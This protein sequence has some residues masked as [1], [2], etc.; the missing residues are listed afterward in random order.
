MFL[1]VDGQLVIYHST[2]G[3]TGSCP[4]TVV[5][6][7]PQVEPLCLSAFVTA[8]LRAYLVF[9]FSLLVNQCVVCG[10]GLVFYFIILTPSLIDKK[11]DMKENLFNFFGKED[12]LN[13]T[14]SVS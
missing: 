7:I 13:K 14:E 9:F 12:I 1:G 8:T 10:I 5:S 3:L 2:D 4:S 11:L 6:P